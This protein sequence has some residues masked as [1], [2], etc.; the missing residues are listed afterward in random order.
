MTTDAYDSYVKQ[1]KERGLTPTPKVNLEM[2][3]EDF[4]TPESA[5][6]KLPDDAK[7]VVTK[8]MLQKLHD[9]IYREAQA[10]VGVPIP[11]GTK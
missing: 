5:F 9:K 8:R 10:L 6:S 4:D 1:C 2:W 3:E 7:L 11:G